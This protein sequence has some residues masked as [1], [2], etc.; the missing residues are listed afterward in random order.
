A[1][2]RVL[3]LARGVS[4]PAAAALL[5]RQKG[6][7]YAVPDYVARADGGAGVP[8]DRGLTA[9]PGGWQKLQWNFL[10]GSG[11]DAPGAWANLIADGRS[12]GKGVVIAVLDTGIAYRD[13]RQF[14]KSPDFT[15]TRFVDP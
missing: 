14:R 4:V 5:R 10:A 7:A 9:E 2:T 11:I 13:W 15:G 12:G 6:V 8:G 3:T 1:T